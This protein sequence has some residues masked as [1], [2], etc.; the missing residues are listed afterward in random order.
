LFKSSAIYVADR[1]FTPLEGNSALLL[2][3]AQSKCGIELVAEKLGSWRRHE[4][5]LIILA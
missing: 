5:F 3:A 1:A 2:A 4:S